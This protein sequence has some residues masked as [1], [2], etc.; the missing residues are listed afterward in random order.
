MERRRDG[1]GRGEME[2]EATGEEGLGKDLV[3]G[4]GEATE[5]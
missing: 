5:A 2:A 3:G 4:L 1:G